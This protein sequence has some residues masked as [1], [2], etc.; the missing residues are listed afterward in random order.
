ME[1]LRARTRHDEAQAIYNAERREREKW[2]S[3]VVDKDA[4]LEDSTGVTAYREREQQRK[5]NEVIQQQGRDRR[6]AEREADRL[7][8]PNKSKNEP[9]L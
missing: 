2:Q 9:S 3:V 5:R 6:N 7:V 4:A 1:I 8:N